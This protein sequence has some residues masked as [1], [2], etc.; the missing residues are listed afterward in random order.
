MEIDHSLAITAAAG[1]AQICRLTYDETIFVGI[2]IEKSYRDE[3]LIDGTDTLGCYS[4]HTNNQ[5]T[6]YWNSIESFGK[7]VGIAPKLIARIVLLHEIAHSV[8]HLGMNNGKIRRKWDFVKASSADIEEA[9]QALV[10]L[11]LVARR[12][13]PEL[14]VFEIMSKHSPPEYQTW[15]EYRDKHKHQTPPEDLNRQYSNWL[16]GVSDRN[17]KPS[18]IENDYE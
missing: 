15:T 7:L 12:Y 8:T 14:G 18:D 16:Y 9:A 6:L 13:E 3:H 2:D 1:M 5:I 17:S 11:F 4:P 10:Y